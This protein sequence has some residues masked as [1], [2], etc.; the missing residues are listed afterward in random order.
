MNLLSYKA[1]YTQSE[2]HKE[3]VLFPSSFLEKGT[4]HP[5]V[6]RLV[7]NLLE[8][9]SPDPLVHIQFLEGVCKVAKSETMGRKVGLEMSMG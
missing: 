5:R 1:F 6:L 9:V 4:L 2:R 3:E 8:Y 7:L